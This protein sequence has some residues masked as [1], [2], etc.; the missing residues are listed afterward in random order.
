MEK[1]VHSIQ[2]PILYGK[3]LPY[4][5]IRTFV[6]AFCLWFTFLF[7]VDYFIHFLALNGKSIVGQAFRFESAH[8]LNLEDWGQILNHGFLTS[9]ITGCLVLFNMLQEKNKL[10]KVRYIKAYKK[11]RQ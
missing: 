1:V 10:Y 5:S 3:K 9:L 7:F 4:R 6:A 11:R 8:F 2:S